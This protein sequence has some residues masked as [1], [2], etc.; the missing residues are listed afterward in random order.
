M[1]D[2]RKAINEAVEKGDL[3]FLKYAYENKYPWA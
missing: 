3:E 1:D 2:I